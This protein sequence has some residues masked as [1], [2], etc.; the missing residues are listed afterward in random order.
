[1]YLKKK[2]LLSTRE[3]YLKTDTPHGLPYFVERRLCRMKV[4]VVLDDV[5]DQQQPE[6]LIRTLEISKN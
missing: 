6:I 1:M 3:Q 4:L 5:N 2:A